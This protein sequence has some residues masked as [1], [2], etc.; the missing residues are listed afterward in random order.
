MTD[1]PSIRISMIDSRIAECEREADEYDCTVERKQ[2]LDALSQNYQVIL[3]LETRLEDDAIET[4]RLQ[5]EH[6]EMMEEDQQEEWDHANLE[7][8]A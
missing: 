4:R 2:I 1:F 7:S 3:H 8:F 6:A 5:R